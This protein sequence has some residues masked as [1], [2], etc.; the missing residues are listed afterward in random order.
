[1]VGA[2]NNND[3]EEIRNARIHRLNLLRKRQAIEGFRTPP[4]IITEI[5]QTQ[6]E[7]GITEDIVSHP[8][9]V[10]LAEQL[11]AGG[12]FLALDK[13]IE[14]IDERLDERMDRFEQA[15]E[16]RLDR[17][18]GHNE[19]RYQSQEAKHESGAQLYQFL[20]V[21][22]TIGVIISLVLVAFLVG[23]AFR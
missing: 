21:L 11:G 23:G 20:F 6:R 9:D 12:R 13:R 1:M 17:M 7:L 5:I 10:A 8:A 16:K 22:L 14:R 4:E 19:E 2:E 15:I 18:E 3:I